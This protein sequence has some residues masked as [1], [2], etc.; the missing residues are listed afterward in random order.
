MDSQNPIFPEKLIHALIK[1]VKALKLYV[2]CLVALY[3]TFEV[4]VFSRLAVF[5][6]NC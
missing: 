5:I 1:V 3:K 4:V 2:E 6:E